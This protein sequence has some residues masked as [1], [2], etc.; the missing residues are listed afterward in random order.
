MMFKVKEIRA[1]EVLDSRGNPT[2]ESRVVLEGGYVGHGIA[3][4]G[5]STGKR[6]ALELRDKDPARYHGRGVRQAV[7]N[8]DQNIMQALGKKSY[9]SL[10][11]FDQALCLLDGTADKSRLGANALVSCSLA[12][13][14]ACANASNMPLARWLAAEHSSKLSMPTPMVNVI[15]GGAHADNALDIQEFMI[16]PLRAMSFAEK[17]R[18]SSEV[19]FTLKA[20]LKGAGHSTNVGDEGGFAPLFL[21]TTQALDYIMQAIE[22]AG[23]K[24]GEDV[25]LALDVAASEFFRNGVYHYDSQVYSA[26]Q[27][28]N[29][30]VG[31]I[32]RY[33]LISLE[34]PLAEDDILGWQRITAELKDKVMLIGDDLL[35]TNPIILQEA[36]DKGL[37]NAII[38]K[39]NQIGTLTEAYQAVKLAQQHGY[40]V[41]VSHRSGESEDTAIAHLAAAWGADYIKTGS[42]SRSDRIAKY[43]ELIRLEQDFF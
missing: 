7:Y 14:R 34:D 19:F 22:Q 41:V 31:L 32:T 17:V 36:I 10:A 23:Y 24:P 1:I 5:A 8:V 25:A 4:S 3:P 30:Y 2:V 42:M 27:M 26:E 12:F 29:F 13:A 40:K 21:A 38:I 39:P 33:P 20:I 9:V 37:A 15:N 43:N 35:V 16:V 18:I 11:E 6:E 28:I